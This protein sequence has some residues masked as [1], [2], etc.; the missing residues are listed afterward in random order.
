MAKRLF[1]TS[2]DYL[3]IAISPALIMALVGSLVFFLLDVLYVGEYEARLTYV[4]ALYVFAS[5]L[6]SRIAIEDGREYA[7]LFAIPLG[8]ATLLVLLKFMEHPSAWSHLI[9]VALV[10]VIWWCADKLTW[11]CTVIDDGEDSS[12]EGLLKRVGIDEDSAHEEPPQ[13]GA[14]SNELFDKSVERSPDAAPWWQRWGRRNKRGHTPGLWVLYFSLAALPLFGVGQHWVPP[15]DV[16]R[17][18]YVFGLL[19]VYVAAALSLLVTN[20]FLGLRRYLRQRRIEMPNPMAATWVAVGAVLILIVMFAAALIP[21]PNAEYAISQVPWQARSPAGLS[22]SQHAFGNDAPKDEQPTEP[23]QDVDENGPK[24]DALKPGEEGEASSSEGEPSQGGK[25][26]KSDE[27]L[28]DK[29][30][31]KSN[32]DAGKSGDTKQSNQ[33]QSS[34]QSK[35]Q[36]QDKSEEQQTKGDQSSPAAENQSDQP[37]DGK[38]SSAPEDGEKGGESGKQDEQSKGKQDG[39]PSRTVPPKHSST[40][41]SVPKLPDLSSVVGGL[42]GIVKLLLYVVAAAAVL[43]LAWK[44]R[45]ELAKAIHDIIRQIRELLACLFG[46]R[47]SHAAEGDDKATPAKGR[48]RS[49]ADFRNPFTTGDYRRIAPEELVRYTFDAFEAWARDGGYSRTADQTPAELVRVAAAP[50]TAL[51]DQARHMLRIYSDVAY[52]AAAIEAATAHSL[53]DFWAILTATTPAIPEKAMASSVP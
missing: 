10:L 22:S 29:S 37:K 8:L 12:G 9:N 20:S 44:Y 50:G 53:R 46:G 1:M 31:Q 23:G 14:T 18:R 16:G 36:P 30:A 2:A 19:V 43:F 34:D 39:E 25:Q 17:R 42:G 21:R 40:P 28:Q 35:G 3:A 52:G 24:G 38:Q 33:D 49:F 5:V 48:Q 51:H 11:D 15:A 27:K 47:A 32:D 13:A 6:V 4:F 7:A 41:R 26:G 45:R